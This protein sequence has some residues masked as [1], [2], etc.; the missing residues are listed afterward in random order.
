[1]SYFDKFPEVKSVPPINPPII[2]E[3]KECGSN[4]LHYF[5]VMP[6]DETVDTLDCSVCGHRVQVDKENYRKSLEKGK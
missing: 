4:V 1:M 6:W 3:C 2:R 5:G